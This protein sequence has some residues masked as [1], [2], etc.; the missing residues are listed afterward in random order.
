MFYGLIGVVNQFF[1]MLNLLVVIR[2]IL[3]WVPHDRYNPLLSLIYKATDPMFAP[4]QGRAVYGAF[5]FSPIIIL[6][7]IEFVRTIVLNL[8]AA[9]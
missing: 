9:F 5:D 1:N 3:S 2:I 7:L 8:F 6:L 4:F